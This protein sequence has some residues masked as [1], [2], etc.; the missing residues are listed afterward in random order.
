MLV[1]GS[2]YFTH[3]RLSNCVIN[4][5]QCFKAIRTGI[6]NLSVRKQMVQVSVQQFDGKVQLLI[7]GNNSYN[8]MKTLAIT[9]VLK[10]NQWCFR[11]SSLLLN[12]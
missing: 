8:S 7:T 10:V 3:Q 9:A 1:Y 6:G 12:K 11:G 2:T 5:F 4:H